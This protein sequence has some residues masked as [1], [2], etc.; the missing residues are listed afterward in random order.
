[1]KLAVLHVGR[2]TSGWAADVIADYGKRLRRWGGVEEIKV[3]PAHFTGDVDAVRQ[4]EARRIHDR[5]RPRDRLVVLDERGEDLDTHQFQAL[6]VRGRVEAEGRVVFVLGGPYGHDAVTRQKAWKVVR[7]SG[8]VMNHEVAR[9]VLYE[10]LYRAM[11][12]AEGV[13]YHH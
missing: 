9:V 8:L 2:S 6:V 5:L 1:M 3:K 10:Q 7:L 13:P 4:E 11:T 12:L